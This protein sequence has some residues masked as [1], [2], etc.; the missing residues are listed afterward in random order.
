V[1]IICPNCRSRFQDVP[2]DLKM[3]SCANCGSPN[4][5]RARTEQER[6]KEA[7]AGMAAGAAVGAAIG[8]LPGAVVG[9]IVGLVLGLLRTPTIE[10]VKK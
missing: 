5:V 8:E 1:W 7:L 9:G 4:L 2:G 3:Y 10:Q 6:S